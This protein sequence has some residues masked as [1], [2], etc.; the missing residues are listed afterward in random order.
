MFEYFPWLRW[1]EARQ[2]LR[3]EG[4]ESLSLVLTGDNFQQSWWVGVGSSC[5]LGCKCWF[6]YQ[7]ITVMSFPFDLWVHS[8]KAK[9]EHLVQDD[10][11]SYIYLFT[12]P[13]ENLK[14]EK[15]SSEMFWFFSEGVII[16]SELVKS[17]QN[18]TSPSLLEG[19]QNSRDVFKSFL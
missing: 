19:E 11:T 8:N 14:C 17:G 4:K 18:L 3:G 16:S 15:P 7:A 13:L 1:R 5:R 12:N 10:I 2:S 6:L 9:W